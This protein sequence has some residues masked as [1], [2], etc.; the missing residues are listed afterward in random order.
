[1][2]QDFF[3]DLIL[4]GVESATAPQEQP[5]Y[6]QE[7]EYRQKAWDWGQMFGQE[8]PEFPGLPEQVGTMGERLTEML[9]G[10]LA[11]AVQKYLT[12]KY[13][14]AWQR[15]LSRLADIGAGPGTLASVEQQMFER[16]AVEGGYL[17]QEQIQAGMELMPSYTTM[18]MSP[19]MAD[20]VE[21]Q[22]LA[23][24]G[25]Q[26]YPGQYTAPGDTTTTQPTTGGGTGLKP[27]PGQ[28]WM[29]PG[30]WGYGGG[31]MEDYPWKAKKG[32][33]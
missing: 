22:N 25:L 28:Q 8:Y 26:T 29:S 20:V 33:Y 23:N 16:Q 5:G 1:M 14:G 21:W 17:G 7:E 30:A 19:Y 27:Y 3:E 2:S 10:E 32:T 13:Q 15:G 18:M 11:P 12:Q 31:K 6:E 24:L 9:S 4:G